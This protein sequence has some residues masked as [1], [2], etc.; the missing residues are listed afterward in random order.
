MDVRLIKADEQVTREIRIDAD[1]F[2]IGRDPSCQYRIDDDIVSSRHC[3]ILKR[4]DHVLVYNGG[5][6]KRIAHIAA[7][8]RV[9]LNLDGDGKG[10]DIIVITGIASVV[11][12]VP[13]PHENPA[14]V[15]K[16]RAGMQRMYGTA[17][18]FTETHPVAIRVDF[19][20]VRGF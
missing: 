17:E 8:P 20:K 5:G 12:D 4:G 3:R 2:V 13:V 11:D 15:A 10:G 9:A 14:F 18:H 6:V 19:H 1:E 16:Y 7:N